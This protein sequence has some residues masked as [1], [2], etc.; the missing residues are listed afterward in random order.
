MFFIGARAVGCFALAVWVVITL[1]EW[2][3]IAPHEA[4]LAAKYHDIYPNREHGAPTLA[5][6]LKEQAEWAKETLKRVY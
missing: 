3:V 5:Q 1:L 2:T 6:V 4:S